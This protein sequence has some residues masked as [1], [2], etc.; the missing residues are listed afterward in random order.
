MSLK[1]GVDATEGSVIPPKQPKLIAES[2]VPL[3][4]GSQLSDN[5]P[6]HQSPVIP[7]LLPSVAHH[8][9]STTT[10][11]IPSR[12]HS[13]APVSRSPA[14]FSVT[15]PSGPPQ[16]HLFSPPPYPST[17][18][19]SKGDDQGCLSP[20]Q[21]L[22]SPTTFRPPGILA[23]S[24]DPNYDPGLSSF[25]SED[26]ENLSGEKL[27][28]FLMQRKMTKLIDLKN[29]HSEYLKE[30]FYL[31]NSSAMVDYLHWKK[32]YN[33]HLN[34]YLKAHKLEEVKVEET[35][36][37]VG[38]SST[39]LTTVAEGTRVSASSDILPFGSAS[40][41]ASVTS[42]PPSAQTLTMVSSQ[43]PMMQHPSRISTRIRSFTSVYDSSHEDIVL[44]AR[45][46]AEV[47]KAISELRKEGLWSASRLPK[48][49]EP[50]RIKTLWD[51]LLEEMQWLATDFANERK[52]KKGA[53]RKVCTYVCV[54]DVHTHNGYTPINIFLCMYVCTCS[55]CVCVL[56]HVLYAH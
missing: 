36:S 27:K 53:A 25:R 32:K 35:P 52:W 7:S 48:V 30:K 2:P 14:V 6:L 24:L 55:V 49:H 5:Q 1:R 26:Q 12:P 56:V 31:L 18:S 51:Y 46:E 16:I 9:L 38:N 33:I 41:L 8:S 4:A 42:A 22:C 23:S 34:E 44:R 13:L 29:K 10:P 40:A 19:E 21:F 11:T 3:G 37:S 45:H 47:M 43:H 17:S 39:Q 54:H 28:K 15:T 50:P 20:S